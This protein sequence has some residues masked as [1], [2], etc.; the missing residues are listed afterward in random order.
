MKKKFLYILMAVS[1]LASSCDALS[2]FGDTNVNPNATTDPKS[3]ALLTNV[4]AGIGG[5]ASNTHYQPGLYA[6]YISETQY[7]DA[8]MYSLAQNAFVGF[9]SGHLNDLKD[10]ATR[11]AENVNANAVATII[12]QYIFQYLTDCWGDLPYSEAL[13]SMEIVTPKYDTQEQIYKGMIAALKD[14]ESKLS[15]SGGAIA[16]DIIY[17]GNVAA[18]K[19]FANSLRMTMAIQL[20]KRYPGA[21][22]YAATEFKAA[23]ADT[24]GYIKTNADNFK[25]N[26]PGGNFKNPWRNTYDGRKDYAESKT[27]TD[28]MASLNDGRQN[29]FGG[30]N[31]DL[32][33]PDAFTTS[34]VGFP[35][36][37][38]RPDA[39]AFASA[40]TNFARVLRGDFRTETAPYVI[41]SAGQ[42]ALARAEAAQR[43]WTTETVNTVY[44]EGITLSFQQW[45]ANV[46]A[47]YFNQSGVVLNGGAGDLNKVILQRYISHYPDG[48]MGWNIWRKSAVPT[49]TP[50]PGAPA[51][52]TIPRR[53]VFTTLEYSTNPNVNEAV[54]RLEG[55]DKMSS[56]IW[57][58]K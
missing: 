15:P 8:S 26:Y 25:L 28:I 51:G 49:L 39:E 47:T 21:N 16:G 20:S 10:Y 37:L 36:G 3:D 46:P 6:Q 34:N 19:K 14:A 44:R 23:L 18:W 24:D 48:R 12:Q 35:Y 41:L 1:T 56:R 40:N 53:F 33:A 2:D 50:A 4:L 42:V 31:D 22:D 52:S 55:G 43:G 7:T 30:A 38:Q 45:G 9:Y 13:K 32:T 58:D 27:M 5:Y 29:A 11:N 57:W 54:A 17:G